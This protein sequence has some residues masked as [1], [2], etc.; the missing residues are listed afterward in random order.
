MGL[1]NTKCEYCGIL[2][3]DTKTHSLDVCI[4]R[5]LFLS[6]KLYDE[7]GNKINHIALLDALHTLTTIKGCVADRIEDMTHVETPAEIGG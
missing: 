5:I 3:D 7:S 6:D 1:T 2:I 4:E